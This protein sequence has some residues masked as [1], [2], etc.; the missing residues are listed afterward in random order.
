ML[1]TR[2]MRYLASWW[3]VDATAC[4]LLMSLPSGTGGEYDED[5]QLVGVQS[6]DGAENSSQS[7]FIRGFSAAFVA[8]SFG[9]VLTTENRYHDRI[10]YLTVA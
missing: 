9:G 2:G 6:S 1:V 3:S 5:Y 4:H 7:N 8:G 10:I